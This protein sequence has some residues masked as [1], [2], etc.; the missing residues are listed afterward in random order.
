M[1]NAGTLG[2]LCLALLLALCA[3]GIGTP[4][5]AESLQDFC[6][7]NFIDNRAINTAELRGTILVLLFGSI[8]CKPCV[9]LLPVMDTLQ[10]HY[11][12]S[13]VRIILLDIDM[14]VD[15]ELQRE[16]IRLKSIKNPYIINA[17]PIAR[18]NKVS[19]LPTTLVVD[20]Q[21]E[22]VKRIMGFKKIRT[23]E[24]VLKKLRPVTVV[25]DCIPEREHEQPPE[26]PVQ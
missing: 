10:E 1:R 4:C 5:V 2:P 7:F 9:E 21:G 16:F 14:A 23:F 11:R 15:P 18:T 17:H 22:I 26:Q 13:D 19:F 6:A 25:P 8:Y 3:S 20:R 12:Y 24:K